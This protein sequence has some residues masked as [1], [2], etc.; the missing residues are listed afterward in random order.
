M[1]AQFIVDNGFT[2][3]VLSGAVNMS[4]LMTLTP[5]FTHH[6]QDH[7]NNHLVINLS[8]VTFI[9]SSIIR[10]FLNIQKRL[11]D[12]SKTLYLLRPSDNVK[13]ILNTT[14]LSKAIPVIDSLTEILSGNNCINFSKDDLAGNQ[15]H[16]LNCSCEICGSQNVIGYSLNTSSYNWSWKKDDIFPYSEDKANN[17][18]DFYSAL[19]IICTECYMCSIDSAHFNV[20]D[21][22]KNII[23]HSSI[24]DKTK[25]LLSKSINKRKRMIETIPGK[26]VFANPRDKHCSLQAYSLAEDCLRTAAVNKAAFNPFLIGY[27]TFLSIKYSEEDKKEEL[28]I[29]CHNWLSQALNEKSYANQIQLSKL[30]YMDL[31]SLIYTGNIREATSIFNK[32]SDMT[33]DLKED[34]LNSVESPLFW[35]KNAEMIWNCEIEKKSQI[36]TN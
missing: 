35:F 13:D 10:L 21:K 8:S 22:N 24:D 15:L 28:F 17:S 31:L 33:Q 16:Q 23:S 6:L 14:N 20:M 11:Q 7:Y 19:P 2:E 26:T 3:V 29:S 30:Y 9:D 12:S 25:M 27:V 1:E 32:F 5:Q 34:G 18:F 36:I 4:T